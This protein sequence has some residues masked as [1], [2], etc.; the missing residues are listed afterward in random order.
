L[1]C[2]SIVRRTPHLTRVTVSRSHLYIHTHTC[3]HARV[4]THANTRTHTHNEHCNLLDSL[5]ALLCRQALWHDVRARKIAFSVC[6]CVCVC[7]CMCLSVCLCMLCVCDSI[8]EMQRARSNLATVGLQGHMHH[9]PWTCVD[10]CGCKKAVGVSLTPATYAPSYR[11][12][13]QIRSRAVSTRLGSTTAWP[14][15]LSPRPQSFRLTPRRPHR[16]RRP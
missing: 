4:N 1:R 8:V 12:H 16:T 10:T 15:P 11:T 9:M 2:F 5:C 14:S 7:V 6:V 13:D 3:T